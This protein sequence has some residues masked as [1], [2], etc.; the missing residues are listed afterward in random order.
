[1]LSL[2]ESYPVLAMPLLSVKLLPI[3]RVKFLFTKEI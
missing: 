2:R 1:M 3:I